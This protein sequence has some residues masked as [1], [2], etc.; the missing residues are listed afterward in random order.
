MIKKKKE[1]LEGLEKLKSFHRQFNFDDNERAFV[2]V[3]VAYLDDLLQRILTE[4]FPSGSG[5]VKKMLSS[6]GR[7]GSFYSRAEMC[8]CL[9]LINKIVFNDLQK[10]GEIRNHFAHVTQMDFKNPNVSK[11]CYGLRWHEEFMMM[12]APK[13]A[14]S[15]ARFKVG[16][17]TLV[18]HL[19]GV[20]SIAKSQKRKLLSYEE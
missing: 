20:V 14:S 10:I 1:Y 19:E 11:L 15:E 3:G 8:Y 7:L 16:L 9:G 12:K 18:S 2:I 17:N 13:G 4:F 6:S 5:T